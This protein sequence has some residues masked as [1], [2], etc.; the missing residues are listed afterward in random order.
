MTLGTALLILGAIFLFIRYTKRALIFSGIALALAAV[1]G[2]AVG[3]NELLSDRERRAVCDALSLT[4][5]PSNDLLAEFRGEEELATDGFDLKY[6]N[7]TGRRLLA[8]EIELV[9]RNKGRS[10][11]LLE[12]GDGR[13]RYDA[14]VPPGESVTWFV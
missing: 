7:G 11:N 12:L 13:R 5:A 14:I 3:V 1:I 4:V 8:I 2:A 10:T 6:T 9:I